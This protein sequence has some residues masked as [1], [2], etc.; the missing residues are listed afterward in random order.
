MGKYVFVT[1]AVLCA[2]AVMASEMDLAPGV[3][4]T[5][6][7]TAPAPVYGTDAWGQLIRSFQVNPTYIG[8]VAV[9]P[10]GYLSVAH[11]GSSFTAFYVYTTAGSF[12]RSVSGLSGTGNGFRDASGRCHLGSGYFASAQESGGVRAWPYSNGGNPGTSSTSVFTA[13]RGRSLSYDG[14][15]YYAT[16]GSYSTPIGIYTSSGSLVGTIPGSASSPWYPK[17]GNAMRFSQ[18]DGYICSATY[19]FGIREGYITTGSIRR[20]FSTATSFC[21]GVDYGWNSDKDL[22][23]GDQASP[24]KVLVY[25]APGG[26]TSVSPSSL[27]KIKTLYR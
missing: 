10:D 25:D 8:G 1:I 4:P 3:P 26:G 27:G 23:V 22:Y 20:S 5:N 2:G 7:A 13:A 15:Y 6:H 18:H 19:S 17:Y 12:V 16:Q 14:T 9:H 11:W 24:S 21:A